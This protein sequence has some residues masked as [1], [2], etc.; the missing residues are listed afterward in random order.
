LVT[1]MS[2]FSYTNDD[3]FSQ[4]IALLS[5]IFSIILQVPQFII[6]RSLMMVASLVPWRTMLS[7]IY[8]LLLW[9]RCNHQLPRIR[10]LLCLV[11]ISNF[12]F[13]LFL[14]VFLAKCQDAGIRFRATFCLSCRALQFTTLAWARMTWLLVSHC[15]SMSGLE[16]FG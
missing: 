2:T 15:L 9:L 8:V 16:F 3:I 12:D 13:G 4:T 14:I 5:S 6:L 1:R 10:W 11:V 7:K